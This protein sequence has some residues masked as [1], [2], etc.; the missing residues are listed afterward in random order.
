MD[1]VTRVQILDKAICISHSANTLGKS[2]NPNILP[3]AMGIREYT[4]KTVE[5]IGLFNLVIAT[6]L[7][8]KKNE[9][10]DV[11]FLNYK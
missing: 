5:Q 4:D 10:N 9:F 8:K 6:G 1:T 7:E 3:P 2:V 11:S